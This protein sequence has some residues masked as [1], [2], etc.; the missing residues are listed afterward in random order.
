MHG[1]FISTR[2][3][4]FALI[5]AA[6]AMPAGAHEGRPPEPHDWWAAW[7][8]EPFVVIGLAISAW[9]YRRGARRMANRS[10]RGFESFAFF[11]GW[12]ALVI[13]LVSPLDGLGSALFSAHMTQHETL[14]LIAAPLLVLGRP[15]APFLLALP[16]HW[17][18]ELTAPWKMRRARLGWRFL[19]SPFIAWLIHAA[20]LWVWHAP[21][22]FRATLESETV[23]AAQHFSF[24]ASA[25]LFCEALIHGRERRLGYG[26]A[27]VYVFTTA[28]HTSALGALLTFSPTLWYSSY[29][30]TTAAWGLTPLEDQ[31]LGGLIMWVPAG[32]VYLAAGLSLLALWLRESERRA[33][34]SDAASGNVGRK[35][36]G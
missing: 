11:A 33:F 30:G 3:I 27:V 22:L 13:A 20:V 4:I 8:F 12:L 7:S 29:Q 6:R 36:S 1:R 15:L 31:Q 28:V 9:L 18:R 35:V 34:R 10:L 26:A 32:V 17:R 14:M 19:V 5:I 16:A 23:H 24:F 25:L 2:A 21:A